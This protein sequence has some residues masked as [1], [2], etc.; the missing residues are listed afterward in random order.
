MGCGTTPPG[1]RSA[2]QVEVSEAWLAPHLHA[3]IRGAI[4]RQLLRRVVAATYLQVW[5]RAFDHARYP[6]ELP[7]WA[8]TNYADP[9]TDQLLPTWDEA[10]DA[11]DNDPD[12]TPAHVMRF[13]SQLDVR[14]IVRG[15]PAADRAIW[16]L[17]KY[18]PKDVAAATTTTRTHAAAHNRPAASRAPLPTLLGTV[19][20]LVALRHPT[21][22]GRPWSGTWVL[23]RQGAPP[24]APR[25]WWPVVPRVPQVVVQDAG[26][27]S[28]RPCPDRARSAGIRWDRRP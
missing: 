10:L 16:Y 9:D 2:W 12:A 24:R 18:L 28:G 26:T 1:G 25:S 17:T 4:P 20:E 22:A 21:Q 27:A 19:R 6:D 3:A 11:I 15:Q 13:G 14:G 7:R 23:P 5:W 8:G